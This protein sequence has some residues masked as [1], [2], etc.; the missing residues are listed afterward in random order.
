MNGVV[1][2]HRMLN[3][4]GTVACLASVFIVIGVPSC[5]P[6]DRDV[7]DAGAGDPIERAKAGRAPASGADAYGGYP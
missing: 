3:V 6:G 5:G 4:K 2:L 7:S 1:R